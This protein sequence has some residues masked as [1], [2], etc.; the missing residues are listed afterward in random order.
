MVLDMQRQKQY[1]VKYKGLAHVHNRWIPERQLV[2]EAPEFS[3]RFKR[4]FQV[5]HFIISYLDRYNIHIP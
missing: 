5:K 3:T 1:L 4:N 2:S